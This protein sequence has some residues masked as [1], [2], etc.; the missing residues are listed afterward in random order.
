[1]DY[2]KNKVIIS[3]DQKTEKRLERTLRARPPDLRFGLEAGDDG[4]GLV[5]IS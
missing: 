2:L 5:L 4:W 3:F 1:M